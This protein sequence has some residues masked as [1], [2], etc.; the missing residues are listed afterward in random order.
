MAYYIIGDG[1]RLRRLRLRAGLTQ[2]E[3]AAEAGVTRNTVSNAECGW[4]VLL[5]TV[6][7]LARVLLV[8]PRE[9]ARWQE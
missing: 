1:D 2:G 7:K 5:K 4:P 3:L 9:V 6:R 8:E